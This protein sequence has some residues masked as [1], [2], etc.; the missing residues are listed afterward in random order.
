MSTGR[1]AGEPW[2]AQAHNLVVLS[3]WPVR[4]RREVREELVAPPDYRFAT[5]EPGAEEST[6]LASTG[7]CW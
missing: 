5:A 4:E 2:V 1:H 6:R 7:R 3:R